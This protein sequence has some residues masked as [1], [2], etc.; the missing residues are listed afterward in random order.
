MTEL[1][2]AI[3]K[4]TVL[5]TGANGFVGRHVCDALIQSGYDVVGS[6]RDSRQER[7]LALRCRVTGNI[8]GYTS[9]TEVLHG[10]DVVVHTAGKAHENVRH[11]QCYWNVNVEGS[12]RLAKE[13]GR[14]KVSRLICI[15]SIGATMAEQRSDLA[16]LS[17]YQKSKLEAERAIIKVCGS[18]GIDWAILRPPMVYGPGAPGNFGWLVRAI[19]R[20]IPLPLAS[21]INKRSFIYIHN[22]ASAICAAIDYPGCVA[23]TLS[24]RDSEIVST[25]EFVGRVATALNKKAKLFR[26]PP[27]ILKR[28]LRLARRASLAS[29][30]IDNLIIDNEKIE[31][32]L[33]WNPPYTMESGLAAT[34]VGYAS[35]STIW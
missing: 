11:A 7:K 28:V 6:V 34:S 5:V 33:G 20:E 3:K 22:L 2:R 18:G 23:E 21:I 31:N 1:S 19:L 17:P 24:L 25:P 15:S 29:S 35:S 32:K 30:L 8:D 16:G 13:A 12:E 4:Q 10:I 26:C 14:A 27:V 9:W